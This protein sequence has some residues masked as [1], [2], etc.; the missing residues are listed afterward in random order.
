MHHQRKTMEV[1]DARCITTSF[2]SP[3]NQTA[4]QLRLKPP[5]HHAAGAS[6]EVSAYMPLPSAPAQPPTSSPSRS[7]PGPRPP[8]RDAPCITRELGD[9]PCITRELGD[10]PCITRKLMMHCTVGRLADSSSLSGEL[11]PFRGRE[12]TYTCGKCSDLHTLCRVEFE[13]VISVGL[14]TNRGSDWARV[15]L[16]SE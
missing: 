1:R 11:L 10:A 5:R 7:D 15:R 2:D 12:D 8:C 9:A 6:A 14:V 16:F 3:P 4:R 13:D